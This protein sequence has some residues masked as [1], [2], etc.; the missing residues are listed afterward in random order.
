MPV[1]YVGSGCRDSDLTEREHLLSTLRRIGHCVALDLRQ[2]RDRAEMLVQ[3]GLGPA[4]A[5]YLALAEAAQAE[6][7]TCDDRLLHQCRRVQPGIWFG[8][9][10]SFCDRE[11]LR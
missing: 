7:I 4:D 3:Q 6:F 1:Y 8:T 5:A 11:D 10:V 9:P 2:A